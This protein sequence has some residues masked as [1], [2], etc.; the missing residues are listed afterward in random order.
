MREFFRDQGIFRARIAAIQGSGIADLAVS[1]ESLGK[2][3]AR[4]H[5]GI[6]EALAWFLPIHYPVVLVNEN[7]LRGWVDL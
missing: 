4:E 3:P 6:A 1:V 2:P 7:S 5:A